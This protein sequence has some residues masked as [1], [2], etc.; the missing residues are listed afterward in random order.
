MISDIF[1]ANDYLFMTCAPQNEYCIELDEE[2]VLMLVKDEV[3]HGIREPILL[4]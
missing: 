2:S 4:W 1:K 3:S